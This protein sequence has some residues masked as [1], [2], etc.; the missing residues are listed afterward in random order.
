MPPGI[1][2]IPPEIYLRIPPWNSSQDSFRNFSGDS[3]IRAR[4]SPGILLVNYSELASKIFPCF[5]QILPG[6]SPGIPLEFLQKILFCRNAYWNSSRKY[7]SFKKFCWNFSWNSTKDSSWDFLG[8]HSGISC[9]IHFGIPSDILP[10]IFLKIRSFPNFS[11]IFV[12]FFFARNLL[13]IKI[14]LFCMMLK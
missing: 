5:L 12:G 3:G 10:G 8:I 11:R 6:I 13:G 14:E 9:V 4:I 2:G 1:F 7:C